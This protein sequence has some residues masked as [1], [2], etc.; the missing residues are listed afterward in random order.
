MATI[1]I[2]TKITE[3]MCHFCIPGLIFFGYNKK[4]EISV[5][6]AIASLAASCF[7]NLYFLNA[8]CI[9]YDLVFNF[10]LQGNDPAQAL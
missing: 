1:P 8:M 2:I 9:V 6:L 4:S 7:W 3:K 10:S 5:L